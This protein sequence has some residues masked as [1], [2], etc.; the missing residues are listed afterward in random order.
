MPEV[1]C[2]AKNLGVNLNVDPV[3]GQILLYKFDRP[4]VYVV[5]LT[6]GRYVIPRQ[7]GY[8]LVG[9][10]LEYV[11]F[12]KTPTTKALISLRASGN[13]SCLGSS[14]LILLNSGPVYDRVRRM[15]FLA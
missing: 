13:N 6:Q 2:V 15:G 12:D 4:R 8:V 11:G 1:V 14:R 3:K 10:T 7:D 9:S 5:V